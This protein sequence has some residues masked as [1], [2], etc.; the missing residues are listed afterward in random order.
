MISANMRNYDFFTIGALDAYGQPIESTEP[1]GVIKMAIH[2]STQAIQDNVNYQNAN[3][4]GLT[5]DAEVNDKYIIEYGK[6]RLKVL[7]VNP[8]GRYKQVYLIKQ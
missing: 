5:T 1:T 6:E 2:L 7:Y 4:V 3:Y 8:Q